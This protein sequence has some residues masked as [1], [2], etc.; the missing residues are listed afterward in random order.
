MLFVLIPK[1]NEF[2]HFVPWFIRWCVKKWEDPHDSA[3]YCIDSDKKWM[4]LSGTNRY[5]VVSVTYSEFF[6]DILVT[7]NVI[8]S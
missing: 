5:G 2:T 6:G 7:L 4:I 1:K 8:Q 3:V